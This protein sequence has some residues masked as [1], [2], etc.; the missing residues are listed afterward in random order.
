MHFSREL[1]LA[2]RQISFGFRTE[3]HRKRHNTIEFIIVHSRSFQT[4]YSPPMRK[5]R[6]GFSIAAKFMGRPLSHPPPLL[7]QMQISPLELLHSV[8]LLDFDLLQG[9]CSSMAVSSLLSLPNV[10]ISDMDKFLMTN[11]ACDTCVDAHGLFFRP[12]LQSLFLQSLQHLKLLQ[13]FH[14]DCVEITEIPY[15]LTQ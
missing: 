8:P 12:K 15:I 11:I 7:N 10:V 14:L 4:P 3:E 1:G 9:S 2:P 6:E 5:A 13:W